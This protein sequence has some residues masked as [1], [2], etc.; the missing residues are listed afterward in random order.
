MTEGLLEHLAPRNS[1]VVPRPAASASPGSMWAMQILGR[2]TPSHPPDQ[3]LHFDKICKIFVCRFR[4]ENHQ[5]RGLHCVF[6]TINTQSRWPWSVLPG[7]G[8]CGNSSL[9]ST[10]SISLVNRERCVGRLH[11][12][13]VC[14]STS[15]PRAWARRPPEHTWPWESL[16]RACGRLQPGR[17]GCLGFRRSQIQSELT[18]ATFLTWN[19]SSDFSHFPLLN[20]SLAGAARIETSVSEFC[21]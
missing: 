17:D 21:L 5:P 10:P 1:L 3:N 8:F 20:T 6:P 2:S 11:P 19:F 16:C 9:L 13:E 7:L 4:S 14:S 12:S 15:V 18:A